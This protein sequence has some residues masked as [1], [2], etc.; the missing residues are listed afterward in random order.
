M[1]DEEMDEDEY[2]FEREETNYVKDDDYS[3]EIEEN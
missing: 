3:E 2:A 1:G